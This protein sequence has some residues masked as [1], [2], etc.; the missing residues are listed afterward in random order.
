MQNFDPITIIIFIPILD[1]LIYPL[2]RKLKIELKPIARITIGFLLASLCL[3]YAALVQHLIYTSAPCYDHP[4]HCPAGM[5]GETLLPNH[6]H[7]AVQTPAYV[8]IGLSEIFISVTGLEYA[9][10]KAPPSMKSFVQS[11]YLFTNAIGSALNEAFVPATGDPAILWMYTG[12]SVAAAT[13]AGVFWCTFRHYDGLEE[14]M[15]ELD[16]FDDLSSSGEVKGRVGRQSDFQYRDQLRHRHL[17]ATAPD[18][19]I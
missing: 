5:D 2:L 10:T 3:A 8:F 12:I 4:G 16:A 14:A 1:R 19:K 7:I 15:N 17:S 11:L 9:Y 6:I 18:E 13:T